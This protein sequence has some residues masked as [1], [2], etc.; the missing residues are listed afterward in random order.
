MD[1]S[2]TSTLHF[3]TYAFPNTSS[4][5]SFHPPLSTSLFRVTCLGSLSGLISLLTIAGNLTVLLSFLLDKNIRQPS[6]FF[7]A[8]LALSD[9]LIGLVSMPLYTMYILMEKT[10]RL[11]DLACDLWLC[12]DYTAC[13]CS[14]YT[15][16][17]ITVDRF[18]SIKIP[19][20]YRLWRTEKKVGCW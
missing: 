7:I 11:G 18:C 13:L 4:T 1:Y 19:A 2:H 20:K 3:V 17:C 8:S 10:W 12:T 15:V 5:L 16:F 14:I 6:N 9:L